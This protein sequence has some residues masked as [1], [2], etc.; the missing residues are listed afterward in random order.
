MPP[1]KLSN[2]DAQSAQERLRRLRMRG[3]RARPPV[4]KVPPEG[5]RVISRTTILDDSSDDEHGQGGVHLLVMSPDSFSTVPL[6]KRGVLTIGRSTKSDVQI[7]D[8]LASREHARLHLGDAEVPIRVED[9]GSANGTRVRDEA[10]VAGRQVPIAPGEAVTIGATVLMVQHNRMSVGRQRLWSHAYFETRLEAECGRAEASGGGFALVRLSFD[11]G[12]PWTKLA[13]I[14]AR[15]VSPPHVFAA[16]GPNEYEILVIE[17]GEGEAAVLLESLRAALLAVGVPIR[18]GVASYPRDGRSVDALLARAN[19][20]LRPTVGRREQA[21][22][23]RSD[24][25][26][27]MQKV[28]EMATRAAT[29]TINVL[30]LGET[31]VGK[32]VMASKLHAMS[33]RASKPFV[34]LNCAGLA[35]SLIE[36]ELFGYEKGAFTGAVQAK[37]GLMETAEGGSIFLDEVGEL[38]TSVQAK[39]LR[40][41]ETREVM[42][43]GALK[44]RSIDVRFISAT[45]RDLEQEVLKGAFRRDLFFR[46]N[47][48]S[49]TIPPLR[50]RVTEVAALAQRFV[51]QAS[52]EFGR[53][54]PVFGEEVMDLLEGYSW[55]GNI[56]ELRNVIERALMLCEG[57]EILPEH[58]P[59]EKMVPDAIAEGT[60]NPGLSPAAS[61][62]GRRPPVAVD[63]RQRIIDALNACVGNQTRA[64]AMLGMPRRTFVSKLD[65]YQIP[66]PQKGNASAKDPAS[67]G[68]TSE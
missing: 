12:M 13:P 6:P 32:E 16:Y 52:E 48:I 22:A 43:V 4:D 45:N 36:S 67:P 44:T 7:E 47:G 20:L 1:H 11:R 33:Q 34:A 50:K 42:R 68:D 41:L 24:Y 17:R 23:T 3:L 55:P 57:N 62:T 21:E 26:P 38:P 51:V 5:S 49:L 18:A 40:V 15:E 29:S 9:V 19:M 58:L 14:F 66:R 53:R 31:G 27:A 8:P 60:T 56:R 46:L 61:P 28:Y 39:L 25:G 10:I 63:E 30:I 54:P 64:A 2:P 59:L 65:L 35:E 37:P